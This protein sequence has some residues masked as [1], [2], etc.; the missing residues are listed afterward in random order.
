MATGSAGFKVRPSIRLFAVCFLVGM[1]GTT[2]R[3]Q[4]NTSNSSVRP[5]VNV[6]ALFTFNSTIGRVATLAI[7]FAVED[8]NKDTSVLAGTRLNVIKQDTNCSGFLG[9]MEGPQSSGIGHVI[10]HVVNELH[11]PLLSFAATDPTLSSLE[12]PY[13]IRTIHSDYFQ[14]NAIADI[15]EYYGWRKVTAIF[16]DDDYGRGGIAALGDAL[17]SR[18]AEISYKAAF[19][20]QADINMITDLLLK[21][22]LME[23]RVFIVHV[24]PDTGLTVF[25]IAKHT[26]M[27]NSGYVWIATDWLAA[28]LDST[29]P[30]D[31]NTMS[32][33]Q[34]V[35][36]L[37]HH[38]ADSDLKTGFLSRWNNEIKSSSTSSSLNTYGMYAYDSVWLVARAI[39]QFF[40]QGGEIVFSKDS[41]LHDANGS[42]LHLEAL[43]GFDRGDQILEQLLLTNFTGLSGDVQFD[44]DRNLIHPAYDII[45]IGGTGSRLIGY[46]SNYSRLSVVAPEILY[47][48][49]PNISTSSQQLYSV[50]W[51]GE[52]MMKPRGWVFPNNGKPLRIGV[53]NKVSFKQFVSNDSGTDN[54]SGYCIDVF[55]TALKLLPYPVP[56]SFILIGDGLTNPNYD[57]LVHMVAQ[58][59]LDAAVGDIAIVRNRTRIVDFTQPY[60]ESGLVIV[61]PVKKTDSIAWAFLKPFTLEMWCVTG[62]FFLF[63][64]AVIWILEHRI[65]EDFRGPPREQLVTICWFSLSTMFFA[66][67]ENTV[68]TLGRFV[69]IIWLFVVLIITSS[70]TAS[71]TS[72]L[73]VQQLSP[74]IKGLDSLISSSDPIGYQAGKFSRNYMIEELNI[75]PSRL[76]PL[77]SPEEYARVL[78]LGPKGGGVAAIVDEIPYVE[79]F[80][81]IYCQFQMVGQEFTKNGWGFAFQRNSPLAED[82]STAILSLSESGDLQ[83]IHDQWL[84]RKGCTSEVT[85]TDTNRLSLGSFWG[86]FLICGLACFIALLVF[87]IRIYCQYNQYN[88]GESTETRTSDGPQPSLSIFNC[89]KRLIHFFDKKEEEVMRA[90]SGK[91]SDKKNETSQN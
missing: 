89:C 32:L 90:I 59:N 62:A 64:G 87:F 4:N 11:V 66:H 31:P 50:I 17:A 72:I 10:S 53:P 48:K 24:N 29:K 15:V 13:F 83:R 40:R 67:R 30:V 3:G 49:P 1:I 16:V 18:R 63:V 23:S 91:S 85:E 33:I 84:A 52:T 46:W 57:E 69:L 34:G 68:S 45:N 47:G 9:T 21:V 6:G 37:R 74:G 60:V 71:L 70:Y 7:E 51:P 20:P 2:G 78:E 79:I 54:V 86:L 81:S 36:V 44:S 77:N 41:R 58:N 65:N 42:T 56:C 26:G 8:V 5:V 12:Y 73:T 61:A 27:M 19:P 39:D 35:V 55:N 22:N 14:M 80:L 28:T 43:K 38:T 82:L 25:S 88:T 76:V 75:S